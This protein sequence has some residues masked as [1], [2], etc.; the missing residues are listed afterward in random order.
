MINIYSKKDFKIMLSNRQIDDNT[1][2]NFLNEYFI[3]ISPQD[4][5]DKEEIF[6]SKHTNV[7]TL[8]FDDV[9]TDSFKSGEPVVRG[10]IFAK[11]MTISQATE[12]IKFIKTI[13]ND[14]EI[15]IHCMAGKSRSVA[16]G[17]FL[18]EWFN[19][20]VEE[21]L[22]KTNP[23]YNTHVYDLLKEASIVDH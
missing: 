6:K 15:H 13:P 14:S 20:D 11:A 22:K 16:F 18:T 17:L 19:L 8:F 5:P 4:G 7:L 10:L 3:S 23:I 12:A 21:F 2:S 1:I 9:L